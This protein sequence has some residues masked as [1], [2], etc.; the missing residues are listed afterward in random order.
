MIVVIAVV[1][2][3]LLFLGLP[4]E[5]ESNYQNGNE[6]ETTGISEGVT[7]VVI[8]VDNEIMDDD[9][10]EVWGL[11][12]YVETPSARIL[13]DTGPDPYVLMENVETGIKV[14]ELWR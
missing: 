13:F 3:F 2:V 7:K 10:V 14:L 4:V 6:R 5:H 12:M 11:A 8:V 1:S 9:L